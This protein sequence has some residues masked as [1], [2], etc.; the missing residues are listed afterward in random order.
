M[1][2]QEILRWAAR[3]AAGALALAV[4]LP[5]FLLLIG[6]R[7]Y[8][9]GVYGGPEDL[10]PD[11]KDD[12]YQ[13]KYEQLVAHGF[14]PL[15]IHWS[16]VGR[17][18]ST[19]T[20]VFGS[21]QQRCLAQVYSRSHNLYL[22]TAFQG[23]DIVYTMDTCSKEHHVAGYWVTGLQGANVEELLAAHR[24]K[25]SAW[26]AEGREA[27]PTPSLPDAPAVFRAVNTHPVNNRL[28]RSVAASN[29]GFTLFLLA[30]GTGLA[31]WLFGFSGPAPWLGLIAAGALLKWL[32]SNHSTRVKLDP[33][34]TQATEVTAPSQP[35]ALPEH[36][37]SRDG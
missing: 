37:P 27:L 4:C 20:Y 35:P 16:R 33:K 9:N 32:W 23:G 30:L 34:T 5:H 18:I 25:V 3:L 24:R 17:T 6:W 1:L 2:N 11:S 14:K 36:S 19:E 8:R 26:A 12:V 7:R 28:L 29:L 15:G 31:G 22:V 21:V 10:S 13:V